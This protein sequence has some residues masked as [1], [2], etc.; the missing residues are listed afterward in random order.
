[1][2]VAEEDSLL[3][4][5]DNQADWLLVDSD[6]SLSYAISSKDCTPTATVPLLNRTECSFLLCFPFDN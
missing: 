2:A 1:M 6:A 5:K 3:F 4:N